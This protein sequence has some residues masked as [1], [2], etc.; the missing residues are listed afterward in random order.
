MLLTLL[1]KLKSIRIVWRMATGRGR[2]RE[3]ERERDRDRDRDRDRERARE[4]ARERLLA[5]AQSAQW[6]IWLLE[7]GLR[8]VMVMVDEGLG[9]EKRRN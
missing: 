8:M 9:R 5:V 3:R 4:R 7:M 2:G 1:V 6:R